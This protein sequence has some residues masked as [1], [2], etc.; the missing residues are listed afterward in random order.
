MPIAFAITHSLPKFFEFER[1]YEVSNISDQISLRSPIASEDV[2]S[3]PFTFNVKHP[4]GNQSN[5][6]NSSIPL[7]SVQD[8]LDTLY[9][10][11]KNTSKLESANLKIDEC[12]HKPYVITELR[13][14]HWYI[15]FYVFGSEVIFVEMLPW[16]TVIVLS[17]LTWKGITVF[18]RNR[19][20]LIR[21][22][23]SGKRLQLSI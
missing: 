21:N 19:K 11:R 18:Q 16:I 12:K 7:F 8:I 14:N 17:L 9:A 6:E 4:N 10:S 20:R 5:S 3:I 2:S 1:C 23:S 13:K 22:K 15:I